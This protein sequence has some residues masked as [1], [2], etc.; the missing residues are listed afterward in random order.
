MM[1]NQRSPSELL[2][3]CLHRLCCYSTTNGV[4]NLYWCVAAAFLPADVALAAASSAMNLDRFYIHHLDPTFIGGIIAGYKTELIPE[5]RVVGGGVEP[6]QICIRGG[7]GKEFRSV[8]CLVGIFALRYDYPPASALAGLPA[9]WGN[10][11]TPL[12]LWA[13]WS[14]KMGVRSYVP[15]NRPVMAERFCH[16]VMTHST[17]LGLMGGIIF[18]LIS[19]SERMATCSVTARG[20]SLKA[21][22]PSA[23]PFAARPLTVANMTQARWR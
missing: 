9:S 20:A 6:P 12:G 21:N 5:V 13:A 15:I 10:S 14:D 11:A 16:R 17:V 3:H 7:N 4:P 2:P 19:W 1:D 18:Q 22:T 8:H 23:L